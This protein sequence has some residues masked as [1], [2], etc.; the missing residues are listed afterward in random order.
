MRHRKKK[1]RLNR[2]TAERKAVLKNLAISLFTYQR[3][4]TTVAKA[5]ALRVFAEPIITLAKNGSDS[6]NARKRVFSK[7]GDED[8]VKILFD[9]V[10]PLY[11]DIPG[12]YLRI[13]LDRRRKG[14]GTQL[15][16]IEL[17][18]R[19]ISDDKL[20]KIDTVRDTSSKTKKKKIEKKEPSAKT[21]LTSKKTHTGTDEEREETRSRTDVKKQK[22]K[23]E[24]EKI[25]RKG[26]FKRFQRKSMG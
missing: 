23:T 4:G 22:A 8:V 1:G 16:V 14:D 21:E 12:G 10:A 6:V 25:A 11:K 3:I 2:K 13:M 24:Q 19:T 5:K 18:K 9:K 7:L 17:T 15:A 26:I 20:L